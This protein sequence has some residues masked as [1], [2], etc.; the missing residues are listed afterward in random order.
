MFVHKSEYNKMMKLDDEYQNESFRFRPSSWE[1]TVTGL[2]YYTRNVD[3]KQ[4][5]T[6][7]QR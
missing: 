7:R 4:K 2:N 1:S 5:I 3:G 6:N